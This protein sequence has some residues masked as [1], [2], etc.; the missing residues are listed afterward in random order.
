[1]STLSIGS[2]SHTPSY[3]EIVEWRKTHFKEEIL[4]KACRVFNQKGY[5]N[6]TMNDI[7]GELG[8]SKPGLYYYIKSKDDI[9]EMII[10]YTRVVEEVSVQKIKNDIT[11]LNTVDA[12]KTYIKD[13]LKVVD[14]FQD[15]YVFRNQLVSAL[16]RDKRRKLF[17]AYALFFDEI[18]TIIQK[19]IVSGDF[20]AT[21][22]RFVSFNLSYMLTAWALRRWYLR[23]L[24]TLE[25][26]TLHLIETTLQ[27]LGEKAVLNKIPDFVGR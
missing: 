2:D 17:D 13:R 16:S 12:L 19:G 25:S 24:Y 18:D 20:H 23:K 8:L 6:T 5:Q 22:A 9:V 27:M 21:D 26:Y 1:M 10:E 14:D 3:Q 11:K 4:L 7:A 15:L